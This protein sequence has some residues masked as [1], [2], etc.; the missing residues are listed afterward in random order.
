MSS[1]RPLIGYSQ[2]LSIALYPAVRPTI[3]ILAVVGIAISLQLILFS[4]TVVCIIPAGSIQFAV[5]RVRLER[6]SAALDK[7]R[8]D[9]GEYPDSNVGLKALVT[10]PGTKGWNGPY[11]EE[12]LRDPWGRPFLYEVSD[13]IPVVRTLG[14]DGQ[15]GGDRFDSDLSSR[16]PRVPIP[17]STFHVVQTFFNFWIAPWVL[18]AA[19]VYALIRTRSKSKIAWNLR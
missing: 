18:L 12:S 15:P 7:Y 10:N 2:A 1:R 17:E 13:G 3:Q 19:S 16:A 14:A 4:L 11:V 6:F 9:C 5:A 8:L